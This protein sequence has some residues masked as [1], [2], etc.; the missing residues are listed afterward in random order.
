MTRAAGCLILA[1]A[2]VLL[3]L[4]LALSLHFVPP[5]GEVLLLVGVWL[6]RTGWGVC[7]S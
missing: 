4:G 1:A 7:T 2:G 6:A 5:F 3:G